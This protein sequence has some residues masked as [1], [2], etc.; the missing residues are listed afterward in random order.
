MP[1][2]AY[3]GDA[4]VGW[5]SNIQAPFTAGVSTTVAS[6]MSAIQA[7]LTSAI[8]L[9][10]IVSGILVMRG[11]VT[12]RTGITRV[13]SASFVVGILMSTAL[14]NEYVVSF[15]TVGLPNWIDTSLNGGSGTTGPATFSQILKN[16]QEIFTMAKKGVSV[17]D[18]VPALL[19]FSLDILSIIPVIILFV[20]Y[21][22]A[23]ILIDLVVCIGPFVLPGY[24]FAATRGVADRF[25]S[26]L[27]GLS[28][29]ILIVNIMLSII[30]GA[31]TTYCQTIL[32]AVTSG[33]S[34]GW[35]GTVENIGATLLM[36]LQ[37]V[38]FLVVSAL[39]MTF[40]PGIA[41]YIGGGVSVSPLSALN[42]AANIKNLVPS[43]KPTG[44]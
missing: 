29:L 3:S 6:A 40:I 38:I 2:V 19:F 28:L 18:L 8:V 12:V 34:E 26:K 43:K 5:D 1:T 16:T 42:A 17:T 31:I 4:F 27:L 22:L 9:W 25:V 39:I 36:C 44:A 20:I 35:F 10:L 23:K 32:G 33:Q 41:S 7:P 14:Y 21:E 15:F 11:E 24:L 30:D 37:L 13:V